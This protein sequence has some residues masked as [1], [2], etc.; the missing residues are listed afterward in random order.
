MGMY[1]YR[2]IEKLETRNKV[3]KYIL[4]RNGYIFEAT[5]EKGNDKR[6]G[7]KEKKIESVKLIKFSFC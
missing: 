1:I 6:M 2:L 4:S 5:K 3:Y 7:W